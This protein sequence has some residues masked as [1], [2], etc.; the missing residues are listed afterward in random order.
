MKINVLLKI[1]WWQIKKEL[2]G[3]GLVYTLILLLLIL[4]FTIIAYTL[5]HTTTHAFIVS[6]VLLLALASFH[7]A[8][9]DKQ[10]IGRQI[11]YP[12]AA[13]FTEYATVTAPLTLS[14]LFTPNWFVLPVT[15]TGIAIISLIRTT[16]KKISWF[17]FL[18]KIIAPRNFEWLS[19][20]RKS[21]VFILILLLL[22]LGLSW[23]IIAPL[24][25]LW[26]FTVNISSFYIECEPLSMLWANE[27]S[28]RQLLWGKI[29][30]HS[31]LLLL[32]SVPVLI[33]NSLMHPEMALINTGFLLAQ[34]LLLVFSILLKYA[35]YRPGILLSGNNILLGFAAASIAIPFLLPVPLLMSL[36]N[37]SRA[38]NNLKMYHHD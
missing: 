23:V 25:C 11:S 7:F 22:S 8:R 4:L 31:G 13:I 14:A 37:Y 27:S 18:S 26:L 1:R 29:K 33:I 32:V 19:G 9:G 38:L 36:R 35:T 2:H 12:Q 21:L 17:V 24:V 20:V 28:P 6:G 5:Y 3:V 16:P 15:W 10:F 34:V 30:R